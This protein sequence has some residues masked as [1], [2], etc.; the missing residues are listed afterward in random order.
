V[1]AKTYCFPSFH[2]H[3]FGRKPVSDR[4]RLAREVRTA[5]ALCLTQLHTLFEPV[6]PSWL[7]TF[8]T[9]RGPNSRH[10]IYTTLVAFWAFLSQVLDADGSCRR[11]VTRVQTLCCALKLRLPDEDTGAYCTARARL[12]IRVL[13]KVFYFI[14]ARL[15][16]RPC[17]GRRMVV[18]DGTSI[19]MPDS[20]SNAADYSYT[21]NQKP[22]CGFPLMQLLGL[23]DLN[24]GAWL[25]VVKS[26]SKAHDAR[27]AWRMLKHLCAGDILLADRAFCSYGFIA[28]C[29]ARGID[30]VMRLHQ[31][32]DPHLDKAKRLSAH[33]WLM[34]WTRPQQCPKG[35]HPASHARA[36]VSLPM[37][38][39][40]LQI[41]NPGFRSSQTFIVTTLL[42]ACQ[43]DATQIAAWYL[44]RWQVELYFDDIKTSLGMDTLRCKSPHMIAR[45]LLMHMI[46][47]N[48]VRYLMLRAEA[49]RPLETKNALSFKG[50][51]DRLDQ[52]LWALW[53]APT[54]KQAK[55]RRDELLQTI[56]N[57]EVLRRPGRK[58]PRVVKSRQNKFTFMTKPRHLYTR[59]DDLAHA[60]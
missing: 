9:S 53:S 13:I 43:H 7:V 29:K 42:D 18:M 59:A 10:G 51:V 57:D 58:Q 22:G 27:L 49:F 11:A 37:R 12:P 47:Y 50:S 33:D 14:A 16:R 34:H 28:V 3:L 24:T 4:E 48:L 36:P 38:L 19:R 20:P 21:P 31:R 1:P 60:A 30:V 41:H 52:W 23:F 39:V 54:E 35:Q 15:S 55:Q 45:E 26:K 8:K 5:D 25:A 17:Q 46:A 6:L 40:D 44:R 2:K 32:R 56:A